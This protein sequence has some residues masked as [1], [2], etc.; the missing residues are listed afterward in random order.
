MNANPG[1]K[2]THKANSPGVRGLQ[3]RQGNNDMQTQY[4]PMPQRESAEVAKTGRA[5]K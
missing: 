5:N 1:G 4:R 2:R 3:A